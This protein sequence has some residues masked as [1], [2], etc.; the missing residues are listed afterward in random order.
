MEIGPPVLEMSQKLGLE[1]E[2]L[3]SAD[4]PARPAT[5]AQTREISV[6]KKTLFFIGRKQEMLVSP[7]RALSS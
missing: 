3:M 6:A 2:A 4:V 5:G 7:L 1:P